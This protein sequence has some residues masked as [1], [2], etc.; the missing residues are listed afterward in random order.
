MGWGSQ[1]WRLWF[2]IRPAV[3][4]FPL[5]LLPGLWVAL[6]AV[7]L[8]LALRRWYDPVPVRCWTV[9]G[10]VLLAL[11]GP[12]LFAG[13][14]LLPLGALTRT[15]PF[16]SIWPAGAGP[17]P[18]NLLQ[19]DLIFQ[20]TPWLIQVREAVVAGTWPLW[21]H[22]AGAGEPLLGN[23]QTQALQPLVWLA[24]PFPVAAGVAVTAAVRVLIAFAFLFL[25]LRRQGISE[26][27][28]LA[29]SLAYGLGG[30][31]ILWLNWPMAN[32]AALLPLLLYAVVRVDAPGTRRDQA[33]L[34]LATFAVLGAGHPETILHLALLAAAF[35][36]SRLAA[37]PAGTRTRPLLGWA[38][39][40][41][42][43]AGLAGPGLLTAAG[44]LPG[45]MRVELLENR[46]GRLL[47][48]IE[49]GEEGA[50]RRTGL[51][52][53]M[54]PVVAPRA[55]GDSRFGT[56]WGEGNS[57]EDAT[58]F[59]GTAALLAA[60]LALLPGD[61]RR[62]PQERV[63]LGASLLA[64][65]VL[66]RAP[67]VTR[68]LLALPVLRD[69][70]TLHRRIL[71]TLGFCVAYLAAC[72]W[73]RWLRGEVRLWRVGLAATGL[74]TLLVWTYLAWPDPEAREAF[75][76]LR[77]ATLVV[78]LAA[79]IVP[80]ALLVGLRSRRPH[81]AGWAVAA[82]VGAELLFVHGPVNPPVPARLFYPRVLQV[83]FV[84]RH[85]DPWHRMVGIGPALR[86]NIPSVYGLADPRTSNPAK[87]AAV[88]QAIR[89]IHG[90]PYRA[91]DGFI[92]PQD[93]LYQLLGVR[94]FMTTPRTRLSRPM[95]PVLRSRDAWV[96]EDPRALPRLFLPRSASP[97]R[98]GLSW[99]ECTRPIGNFR[100]RSALPAGTEP[101]EAADPRAS[102]L[103]LQ[104]LHPAWI[105]A[106]A[107]LAEPR[108][109]AS[110]V[111]Q[112][113]GWRLL[114]DGESQPTLPVNG[115]FVAARL[116]A[117]EHAV[118]LV[119][120]P[121]GFLAGALGAALALTAALVLWAPPPGPS[122]GPTPAP[123]RP[124]HPA[125]PIPG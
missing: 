87:P 111:Y 71:L 60:F 75:E 1:G 55:F 73:E 23:P 70:L 63:V 110:S 64:V 80:A 62:F 9:W 4:E 117:G 42:I 107:R 22:L 15:P 5:F 16:R 59:V 57:N 90:F 72:A 17:P 31:L 77:W 93:A 78:Q 41:A 38:A 102:A 33:L 13:R 30:G 32:T 88:V 79:L 76:R 118:E 26:T 35:A 48:Q 39:A 109:L 37:R 56:Y 92:R 112:D 11:F 74:G 89:R 121:G 119:Y 44:Y 24:L 114:V 123:N 53:R 10:G 49:A 3:H 68:A 101:W 54:L 21:N 8:A 2:T 91:T 52:E 86:A 99:N 19:T 12:A 94:Y 116:P 82:C 18:G 14:V 7:L 125:D 50:P 115:P 61:G 43:G 105:R 104:E 81:L 58:A 28:A 6:L 65:V 51:G 84:R 27:P 108:L 100:R 124:P 69:S 29:G 36:L 20:I 106:R 97:C 83:E 34:A 85:L 47:R 40:V 120:R 95:R 67:W 103:D 66:T 96:W 46:R 113:G 45:S 98:P 25:L 122:P